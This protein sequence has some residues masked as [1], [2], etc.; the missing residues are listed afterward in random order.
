MTTRIF[1]NLPVKDLAATMDFFGKLGFAFNEK[2]TDENAACMVIGE[3]IFAMFLVEN[4]FQTFTPKE[5]VDATEMTEVLTA[6]SVETREKVDEM[7]GQ[8]FEAGAEEVGEPQD[9]GFMYSR[10]FEDPD[11]HIWEI[12]WMDEQTI[13]DGPP[14]S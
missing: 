4:F 13:V 11:G 1:V 2:F 3:N 7:L 8:A 6:L 5:I 14:K 10:S 12:L 9:N